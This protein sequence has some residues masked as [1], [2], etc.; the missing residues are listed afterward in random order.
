MRGL[1][2]ERC[3]ATISSSRTERLGASA[4]ARSRARWLR[5]ARL[6]DRT[7][8]TNDIL[9]IPYW[10][11]DYYFNIETFGFES[12]VTTGRPEHLFPG[13]RDGA[14]S[15]RKSR[16]ITPTGRETAGRRTRRMTPARRGVARTHIAAQAA[17]PYRFADKVTP[18]CS[19]SASTRI[20]SMSRSN[21]EVSASSSCSISSM[22]QTCI[23]TRS[24]A[25]RFPSW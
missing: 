7:L 16:M 23:S 12:T 18:A 22:A 19:R 6:R 9:T 3:A 1:I 10:V 24:Y 11:G 15:G 13:R 4:M 21:P 17:F 5:R 25:S 20:R 8:D 14:H 2:P